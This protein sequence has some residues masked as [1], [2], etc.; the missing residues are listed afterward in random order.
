[1]A[2]ILR[3]RL[4]KPIC[5][6]W[7]GGAKDTFDWRVDEYQTRR[8][9]WTI[10]G[11]LEANHWFHVEP[12]TTEKGTLGNARRKLVAMAKKDPSI[13]CTFEYLEDWS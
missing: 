11:S 1:M 2:L 7:D 5:G 4:S 8:Q 13:T 10:V 9:G 12:G 6:Y 3:Q